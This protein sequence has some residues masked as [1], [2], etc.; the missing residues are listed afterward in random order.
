MAKKAITPRQ[1][2]WRLR[3]AEFLVR[4]FMSIYDGVRAPY[5]KRNLASVAE[6]MRKFM[7]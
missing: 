6:Q 4:W 7:R 5:T 1:E 2:A 3:R